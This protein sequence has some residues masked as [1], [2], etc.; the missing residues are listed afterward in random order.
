M[1]Q[2]GAQIRVA[3]L[4]DTQQN[5]LSS[6]GMLLLVQDSLAL[7]IDRMNLKH[8]LCQVDANFLWGTPLSVQV[9]DITLPLWRIDAVA[10][11]GV[12]RLLAHYVQTLG[13]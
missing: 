3:S 8:V 7:F 9:A 2:Q 12:I 5:I 1:N 13:R 6:A 10:G 4:A 11:G